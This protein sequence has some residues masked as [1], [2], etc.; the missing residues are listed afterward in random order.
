MMYFDDLHGSKAANRFY[1]GKLTAFC[2]FFHSELS[3]IF[4]LEKTLLNSGKVTIDID[5]E[6]VV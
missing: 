2:Y 1:Q 3:K 4:G 5:T 6:W